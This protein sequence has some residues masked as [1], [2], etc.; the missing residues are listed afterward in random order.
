MREIKVGLIGFGTVG[1]GVVKILQKNSVLI[2][3]RMGAKI[4]LKRIADIDL[5]K[6]REVKL[7]PGVLTRNAEEV[8]RDPEI[9]I[10]MELMG[11]IEP[12][13]T[14][15]L[16]AIQNKKHIVTANKALLA[17]HG[18]EIFENAYRFGI[19]VNFEASVG[20]G[21]PLIRSI[22]EGLVANRIQS[23]F[24]ILNGTSN[25]IL[26]KMTNEGRSFKE[27][28]KEAQEKGYAEAD[29]TYDVE[30]T[31]TAHKLAIL[32]RLAFGTPARFKEI[33]IGGISEITPLDIQFSRE[34]GYRIKLLAIAKID[35]GKIEARVHPTMIPQGHLLSTVG[36]VFNAI[37][38]KGDA[39]GPTLFYGQ[40]AGQM[41]TGSAVLSDLVELGRNLL[42]RANGHR[43]P[44]LSYQEFAIEKIPLKKIEE[45]MMPFYMRFSALDRPGVLSK[46]SGILGK[47]DISIAS[48]IQKGRRIKGGVPIV[49]MTHE[50]KEKN[51]HQALKEIDRLGVILG[52][53]MYIRVENELE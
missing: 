37:Y 27:V 13:R 18:E 45:V 40:G 4:V 5:E 31:D 47:H 23:I 22:K 30:G 42:V 24:G 38:I 6:D 12:A 25:Y 8:I 20:G 26:S 48:V 1:S 35:Q 7:K 11:G 52:K 34:F 46:I 33:F 36:G 39:V 29:P 14:Y 3:K 2:E 49:M 41:P 28:L 10:V 19:D 17:L 32:I 16:K 51:V 50:A 21:I 9:D 43:V 53:T 44:S 15:I